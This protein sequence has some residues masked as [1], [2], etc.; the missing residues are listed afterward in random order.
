MKIIHSFWTKPFVSD[1][2]YFHSNTGGWLSRKHFYMSWALSCLQLKT[3]YDEVELVT[4]VLGKKI[5]VDLMG[6]PYSKVTL[7]LEEINNYPTELWALGKI[8]AYQ[9]QKEPFI[10]IDADAFIWKRFSQTIESAPLIS[11]SIEIDIPFYKETYDKLKESFTFIPDSILKD[12][13]IN[14]EFKAINAGVLGAN[15]LEFIRIYTA[16][17]FKFIEQNSSHFDKISLHSFNMIYE[18]YL[19][20]CL[21]KEQEIP[22]EI[23]FK[24]TNLAKEILNFT[25]IPNKTSYMH[26]FSNTKKN[27][28]MGNFLENRLLQYF[29]DS[30]FKINQ[31]LRSHKI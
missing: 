12:R 8:K 23:L 26:L 29:P 21:A 1:K 2:K 25:E 31:L 7:E 28:I 13:A 17:C 20:Y 27:P 24:S 3:F 16:N 19:F 30:Y 4:D 18:Q 15:D 22:I 5:L 6:L 9:I 10:H 11:Q 14:R